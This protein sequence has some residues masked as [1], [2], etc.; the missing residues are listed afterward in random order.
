[1]KMEDFAEG[2]Q[3]CEEP[4]SKEGETRYGFPAIDVRLDSGL[5]AMVGFCSDECK[6]QFLSEN[7]VEVESH[8]P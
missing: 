8:D 6:A 2:C 7:E 1:M 5:V 3:R 4:I